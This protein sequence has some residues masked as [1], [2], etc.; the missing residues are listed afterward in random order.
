[1]GSGGCAG[2]QVAPQ[3]VVVAVVGHNQGRL[4]HAGAGQ[5]GEQVVDEG[6]PTHLDQGPGRL[7]EQR[8]DTGPVAGGEQDGVH[9]SALPDCGWQATRTGTT[10]MPAFA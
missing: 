5:V 3:G 2:G 8:A 10:E 7:R 4:D 6:A 1:M 9:A